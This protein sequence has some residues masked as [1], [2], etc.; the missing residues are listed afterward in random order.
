[1]YAKIQE[2]EDEKSTR[3]RSYVPLS[4][5]SELVLSFSEEGTSI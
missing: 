2:K 3:K 4:K 1:M 5:A